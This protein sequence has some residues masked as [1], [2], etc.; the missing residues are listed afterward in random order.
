[1]QCFIV[2]LS[3]NQGRGACVLRRSAGSCHLGTRAGLRQ[4]TGRLQRVAQPLCSAAKVPGQYLQVELGSTPH[5]G[6]LGLHAAQKLETGQVVAS[7][8]VAA[9]LVSERHGTAVTT[10][11]AASDDARWEAAAELALRLVLE[12]VQNESSPWIDYVENVCRKR[13]FYVNHPLLWDASRS[14]LFRGTALETRRETLRRELVSWLEERRR[15]SVLPV[16]TFSASAF[17]R[18]VALVLDRGTWFAD[19]GR[20][21]LAPPLDECRPTGREDATVRF[22]WVRKRLLGGR[23][24]IHLICTKD[25]LT[26]AELRYH[27]R[28]ADAI[29]FFLQYGYFEEHSNPDSA[30][31]LRECVG[32][33]TLAFEISRLD[34]FYDDKVDILQ[35]QQQQQQRIDAT[36]EDELAGQTFVVAAS[37]LTSEALQAAENPLSA[38]VQFLRLL[39]LSGSDAF[40][41]EGLFRDEV[42][43]FLALPVSEGNERMVCELVLASCEERMQALDEAQAL[44]E[45]NFSPELKQA[46]QL[47]QEAERT[48]LRAIMTYFRNELTSLREKE[49][50]HERR[51]RALDLYRPLDPDEIHDADATGFDQYM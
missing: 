37:D 44:C 16:D 47:V 49:Y 28:V 33:V 23:E 27:A 40:L 13:E 43:E 45:E 32:L 2:P 36:S 35:Q 34:R 12:T 30:R 19:V 20:W 31:K 15:S 51:L 22:Q 25:V 48:T 46:A 17:L 11:D 29:D 39:C 7:V 50:Y 1:M 21:V 26:G 14:R 18:A 4:R 3:A 5:Q 24:E 38:M 10:P 41:L 9:A 6:R 42:W 8:E